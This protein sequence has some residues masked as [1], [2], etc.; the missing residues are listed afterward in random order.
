M[1]ELP[2]LSR[3]G[4]KKANEGLGFNPNLFQLIFRSFKLWLKPI[5]VCYFNPRPKGRGNSALSQQP[6][7][8]IIK[9]IYTRLISKKEII[10]R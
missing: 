3:R 10:K 4:I 1:D 6:S 5:T 2:R 8:N 9:L 7:E